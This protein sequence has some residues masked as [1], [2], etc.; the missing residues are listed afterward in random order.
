MRASLSLKLFT[1]LEEHL[2]TYERATAL[3]EAY[4]YGASMETVQALQLMSTYDFFSRTMP[5]QESSWKIMSFGMVLG[6]G[7]SFFLSRFFLSFCLC[8]SAVS[9]SFT[10]ILDWAS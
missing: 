4:D 10:L 2:P 5:N 3:A 7:V 6:I 8:V 9:N 1:L